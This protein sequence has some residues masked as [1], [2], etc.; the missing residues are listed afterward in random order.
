MLWVFLEYLLSFVN[1]RSSKHVAMQTCVL[2]T[3]TNIGRE[4]IVNMNMQ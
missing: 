2:M 3:T 1:K 4:Q